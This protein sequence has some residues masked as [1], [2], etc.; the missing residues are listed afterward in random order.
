MSVR[1]AGQNYDYTTN[2]T[3]FY[4]HAAMA[5]D[6]SVAAIRLIA[7]S[8]SPHDE[9]RTSGSVTE[10]DS[11]LDSVFRNDALNSREW[12]DGTHSHGNAAAADL[13]SALRSRRV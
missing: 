7:A 12:D 9:Y 3:T 10:V 2:L 4:V 5:S 8:A 1:V 6:A 13:N 11:N